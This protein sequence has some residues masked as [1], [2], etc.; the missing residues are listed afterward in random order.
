MQLGNEVCSVVEG[1]DGF[2]VERRVNMFVVCL[3]VFPADC[4]NGYP[5]IFNKRG[6][7]VILGAER[8][9]GAQDQVRAGCLECY[10]KIG[11]LGGNVKAG[12][13]VFAGQRFLPGESLTD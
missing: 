13:N 9:L 11:G 1:D 8:I 5:E 6:G 7:D 2:M 12:G 4:E 3:A 10:G